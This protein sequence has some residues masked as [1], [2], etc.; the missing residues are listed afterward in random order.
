MFQQLI[1]F[2]AYGAVLFSVVEVYLTLNKLWSRKHIKEVADSISISARA[3][4]MIPGSIFTLNFF[5]EQQW[6]GFVDGA[7]WLGASVV[8]ILVAGGIWVA[9]NKRHHWLSLIGRSIGHETKEVFNLAKYIF[10]VESRNKVIDLLAATALTDKIL[11]ENEKNFVETLAD[12]WEIDISWDKLMSR[13]KRADVSA[14]FNFSIEMR[15]YLELNPGKKEVKLLLELIQELSDQSGHSRPEN[16]YIIDEVGEAFRHYPSTNY[17][18]YFQVQIVPQEKEQHE[19][20]Q[21]SGAEMRSEYIGS[22][23]TYV[24]E[25]FFTRNFADH[26]VSEFEA[27]GYFAAV[28]T[29]DG[30]AGYELEKCG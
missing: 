4:G 14:L 20:L 10:Q 25:P 24:L 1:H 12:D 23:F 13:F 21:A 17:D 28:R 22:G 19:R 16:Q 18:D 7:I 11:K 9:G 26:V 8:Q 27:L 30:T 29:I 6:Q 2:L 5:F 3:T 15:K